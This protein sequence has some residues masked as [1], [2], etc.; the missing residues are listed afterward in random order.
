MHLSGTMKNQQNQA[1]KFLVIRM[2][3]VIQSPR[4]LLLPYFRKADFML[5]RK[6][7]KMPHVVVFLPIELRIAWKNITCNSASK[8]YNYFLLTACNIEQTDSVV[9]VCLET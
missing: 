2:I 1:S 9:V 8:S 5:W 4:I 6:V 7:L 3:G